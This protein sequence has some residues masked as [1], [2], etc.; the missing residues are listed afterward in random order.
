MSLIIG[1]TGSIATGKSTVAN[2]FRELDI[3]VIDADILAR[4]VVEPG[5]TAYKKVVQSFGEDILLE[6]Q[7]LNRKRLGEIVFSDEV[8]RKQLNNIVH[9]AIRKRLI[10]KRDHFITSGNRCIV[11]DIPLLFESKLEHFADK[12][13]VVYVN[14]EIQLQRLMKRNEFTEEEAMQR[15]LSQMPV[16]EKAARADRTINN[17]GSKE[18][19][20]TQ[21]K[22]LLKE[23]NVL[24]ADN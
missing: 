3:P 2:M 6:D 4:E 14:Q 20:Y 12:T 16:E 7:T 18:E 21:L 17:N 5:E 11:L 1:L 15:I 10:E 9:P 22:Q 19:T 8:K 13:L 23:W 24:E